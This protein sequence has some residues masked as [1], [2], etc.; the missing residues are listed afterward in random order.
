VKQMEH[1]S[2]QGLYRSR[3]PF[4]AASITVVF[5]LFTFV[6]PTVVS[7]MSKSP[8]PT[9]ARLSEETTTFGIMI[10][11]RAHLAIV[12]PMDNGGRHWKF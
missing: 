7:V 8:T 6:I 10:P 4:L 9:A 11:S 5:S 12:G 3:L 2:I 1:A